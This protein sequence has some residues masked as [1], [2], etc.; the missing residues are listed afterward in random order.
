MLSY[1][2]APHHL[3]LPLCILVQCQLNKL[4]SVSIYLKITLAYCIVQTL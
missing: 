4:L 1:R 3:P 2:Y